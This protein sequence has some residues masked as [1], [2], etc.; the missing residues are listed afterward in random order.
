M[1]KKLTDICLKLNVITNQDLEQHT[2]LELCFI[3]VQRLNEVIDNYNNFIDRGLQNELLTIMNSWLED[4]TMSELVQQTAYQDLLKKLENRTAISIKDFG[5]VGD[6]ITDDTQAIQ[7][8]LDFAK[9][10]DRAV[11]IIPISESPYIFT[12][13][14]VYDNTTIKGMGGVLKLKDGV[15]IDKSKTYYLLFN[16]GTVHYDSLIIDGNKDNNDKFVVADAITC[17]NKNSKVTNCVII[18]PPD[19][20]IMLSGV[21]MGQCSNNTISGA[22]DLGIYVHALCEAK[23]DGCIISNNVISD[24]IYGGIGVK[25]ESKHVLISDNT[26]RNCGNG[27]TLEDFTAISQGFP[28][29]IQIVNNNITNI[30]FPFRDEPNVAERGISISKTH[31]TMVSGNKIFNCSGE[32]IVAENSQSTIIENNTING[33]PVNPHPNGNNGLVIV[34]DSYDLCVIGNRVTNVDGV[35]GYVKAL[36]KSIITNNIFKSNRLFGMRVDTGCDN[37]YIVGNM[38]KGGSEGD[39]AVY[40]INSVY[41]DNMLMSLSGGSLF[42]VREF[43]AGQPMPTTAKLKPQYVG[44]ILHHLGN[45]TWWVANSLTEGDWVQI[46]NQ[47]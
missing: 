13:L 20:G 18:N 31:G 33:Y 30:G 22:S 23:M 15:C 34:G 41:K 37:N 24:C 36:T 19:S 29:N 32:C 28:T 39:V 9:D 8:A 16:E 43:P 7:A 44:E 4:G 38:C 25:R 47:Q 46:S 5:A 1:V 21:E 3:I 6:G 10:I 11:V 2:V 45:N 14:K 40:P 12:S 42:G 17:C 27:I 26:I 35:G